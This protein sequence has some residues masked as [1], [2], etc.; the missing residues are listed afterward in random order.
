MRLSRT[1]KPDDPKLREKF[2]KDI[3]PK[4]PPKPRKPVVKKPAKPRAPRPTKA[5]YKQRRSK[6]YLAKLEAKL[7]ENPPERI[8]K[9][10]PPG[11]LNSKQRSFVSVLV[12]ERQTQTEA[13]RR[14]GYAPESASSTARDLLALPKIQAAVAAERASYAIA[15]GVTKK[16]VVDGLIEAV[17]MAKL[18]SDPLAM[19]AGW[20][21]VGKMLGFYE[22]Q[23]VNVS[24][25]VTG[26]ALLDKMSAMSDEELMAQIE[27]DNANSLEGEFRDITHAGL[28]ENE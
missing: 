11:I 4:A 16:R 6:K 10:M 21:E 17:D 1:V 13:A 22:P 14:A 3:G 27:Q 7:I 12:N 9:D 8:T 28:D 18:M 5:E 24:V 26:K 20:R 19:I 2:A 25:S 23:K 15:S